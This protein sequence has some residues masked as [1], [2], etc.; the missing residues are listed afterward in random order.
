[1]EITLTEV[2][3]VYGPLGVLAL[4]GLV[5]AGHMFRVLQRERSAWDAQATTLNRDHKIEM[6][7]MVERY[8]TTTTMQIEQYHN[9]AEKLHN[10]IESIA[11]RLDR[12]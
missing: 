11:R 1:M 10:M 5:S 6:Q 9:L 7:A 2:L 4:V 8:I 3:T 12:R